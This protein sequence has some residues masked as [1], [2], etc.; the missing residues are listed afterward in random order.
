MTESIHSFYK[1]ENTHPGFSVDCVI[2]SFHEGK[3]KILLNTFYLREYWSL[4][5]GFMLNE[6]DADQAAYRILKSR[7]GLS[8]LFL[9]QFY[10][11][12]NP[13]RTI[14]EQNQRYITQNQLD[15]E[16]SQWL[17]RR[18]VTLGYYAAVRYEEVKLPQIEGERAQWYEIDNLPELY[19]DHRYII[20]KSLELI[21]NML[22]VYPIAY[23]LLPEKFTMSELRKVYESFSG[24]TLDRR[25]FQRKILSE[26]SVIQLKETKS[27]KAYNAPILY[28]FNLNKKDIFDI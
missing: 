20:H 7:T 5:G 19:S 24:K 10:L 26:G 16:N 21:R 3:L 11:F 2:L 12:S 13:K 23:N 15:E 6:E 22:P 18:F 27:D 8:D 14:L 28:T 4:P 17:L 25:N 9:R 1:A